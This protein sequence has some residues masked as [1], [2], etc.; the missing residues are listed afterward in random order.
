ML[1]FILEPEVRTGNQVDNCPRHPNFTWFRKA[2]H[3]L[4]Q[5]HS[6]ARHV[7]AAAFDFTRMEA[8][9]NLQP[10]LLKSLPELRR[11][12]AQLVQGRR[13]WRGRR[14]RCASPAVLRNGEAGVRRRGRGFREVPSKIDPLGRWRAQ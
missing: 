11:R 2:L 14:H 5:M 7:V 3:T 10:Q 1:T 6:Y 13:R 4:S 9:P 8:C 12:I